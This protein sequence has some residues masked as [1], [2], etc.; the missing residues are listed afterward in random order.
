M[1]PAGPCR[2]QGKRGVTAGAL[3]QSWG[4]PGGILYA[5]AAE[6][7]HDIMT[8]S[9]RMHR[10]YA[11][12]RLASAPHSPVTPHCCQLQLHTLGNR[13]PDPCLWMRESHGHRASPSPLVPLAGRPSGRCHDTKNP[14]GVL[15]AQS[16]TA[17]VLPVLLHA[18]PQP[19]RLERVPLC[20]HSR[21]PAKRLGYQGEPARARLRPRVTAAAARRG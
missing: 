4:K 17:Q 20:V 2:S 7:G 11:C 16:P 3:E 9:F 12:S 18:S 8:K 1:K 10:L 5:S 15:Q 14:P 6:E 21:G 19:S 13:E